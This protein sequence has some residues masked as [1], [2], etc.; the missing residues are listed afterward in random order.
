MP[1]YGAATAQGKLPQRYV[2]AIRHQRI[3]GLSISIQRVRGEERP[4]GLAIEFHA[5]EAC[6]HRCFTMFQAGMEFLFQTR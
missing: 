2:D 4:A 6:D 1:K 3:C 5:G